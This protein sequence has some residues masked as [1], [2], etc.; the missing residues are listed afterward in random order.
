[1]LCGFFFSAASAFK[2]PIRRASPKEAEPTH[3]RIVK[4][5]VTMKRSRARTAKAVK[6]GR[7]WQG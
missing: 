1:V 3:V 5:T 4:I 6:V 2:G 7:S